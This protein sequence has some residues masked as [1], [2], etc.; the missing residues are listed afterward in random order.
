MKKI[1]SVLLIFAFASLLMSGCKK[2]VEKSM[3]E[4]EIKTQ[5]EEIKPY[6]AAEE[7]T[8]MYVTNCPESADM[9]RS[10]DEKAEKIASIPFGSE[11]AMVGVA[12]KGYYYIEYQG[13][14]GYIKAGNL[15][16][17][18][19]QKTLENVEP[20]KEETSAAEPSAPSTKQKQPPAKKA[21]P[22]EKK[23]TSSEIKN[24][25]AEIREL[26]VKT[27]SE[28]KQYKCV[29][30]FK[31]YNAGTLVHIDIRAGKF[32]GG[33]S[34]NYNRE[35]YFKDGELKF[36]FIYNESAQNRFYFENGKMF[37]WKDENGATHDQKSEIPEYKEWESNILKEAELA[38][39]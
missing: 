6:I 3:V 4:D 30:G 9:Y 24:M 37:R 27:Q 36:A 5:D 17:E 13:E 34:N 39:A 11:V 31:Y 10:A 21:E 18:K 26:Y 32:N 35:Y 15:S 16:K 12:E 8:V 29:S 2:P 25:V 38:G 1:I 28:L 19:P 14:K 22:T 33:V 20:Y 7:S 23:Y